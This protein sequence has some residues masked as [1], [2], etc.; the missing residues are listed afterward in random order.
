MS[1]QFPDL[2]RFFQIVLTYSSF[3][4]SLFCLDSAI[5]HP[6]MLSRNSQQGVS[7]SRHHTSIVVL[8]SSVFISG[9]CLFLSLSM[10]SLLPQPFKDKWRVTIFFFCLHILKF[11]NVQFY[12]DIIYIIF[13]K[14]KVHRLLI[15]C[16]YILQN[17]C[18]IALANNSIL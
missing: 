10:F 16:T 5:P 8:S 4:P 6:W 1:D 9:R 7:F 15:W 18:S 17:D 13:C 2:L 14:F 11:K 3:S 12:W